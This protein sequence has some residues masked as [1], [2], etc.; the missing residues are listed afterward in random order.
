MPAGVLR[1]RGVE[2]DRDEAEVGGREL[3]FA[4]VPTR[5]AARLELL[6]V[7]DLAYVHLDREVPADRVLERFLRVEVATGK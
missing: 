5:V 1:E 7:R 4:R 6:E 2:V 3:P